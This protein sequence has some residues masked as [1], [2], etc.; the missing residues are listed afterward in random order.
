M[1]A[2][3]A[4][5]VSVGV[6]D[7]GELDAPH[8]TIYAAF[9]SSLKQRSIETEAL[10]RAAALASLAIETRRIYSDL[11]HR[12]AFDMLTAVHNRFSLEKYLDE[13][14]EQS[15]QSAGIFGLLYIDLNEFKQVN[16]TYGHKVGDLYLQEVAT[17]LKRQ[18]RAVDMLARIGGDEFAVLLP[19]VRN[20]AEVEEV[21]RRVE[22]CIDGVFFVDNYSIQGSASIGIAIYPE[23][24]ETTDSILSAADAAMYVNKQ[25]R[26]E[27]R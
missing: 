16:D 6:G 15:R 25:I 10:S 8:G 23:D 18:L 21:A 5:G 17:R 1:S 7:S 22:R 4:G 3:Q 24:G 9:H 12:S 26:R 14:I 19:N 20:H 27:S 13:Q 11:T 2:R